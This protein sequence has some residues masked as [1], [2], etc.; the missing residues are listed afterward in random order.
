[1]DR[2]FDRAMDE[3]T[4]SWW[5]DGDGEWTRHSIDESGR[6]LEDMQAKLMQQIGQR[7]RTGKRR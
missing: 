5:L 4:S 2:L 1:M 6:P 3:G 7:T